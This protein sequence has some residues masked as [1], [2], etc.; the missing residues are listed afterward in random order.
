MSGEVTA[1]F[2]LGS[3]LLPGMA[4]PLH[5]FE[6]RYRA[7]VRH[8]LDGDAPFGVTLI[9][10]GSEVGGGDQRFGVGTLARIVE[11]REL[12]DG[13]FALIAVGT[14]RVTVEEW[15]ADDP[16]PRARTQAW[17][18]VGPSGPLD[19]LAAELGPRLRRLLAMATEMGVAAAPATVDLDDDPVTRGWQAIGYAPLGSLDRHRLL[20]ERDPHLRLRATL[21]ALA[22]LTSLLELQVDPRE[23]S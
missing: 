4:L 3:V 9:E 16:Y 10:R 17:P 8:C 1:M 13:R 18:D 20:A 14:D 5:V 2:P 21:D 23:G 15:L 19:A 6:D 7:L 22:E 12:D 11:A